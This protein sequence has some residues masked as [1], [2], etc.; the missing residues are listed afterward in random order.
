MITPIPTYK[1]LLPNAIKDNTKPKYNIM[2]IIA[3]VLFFIFMF[4]FF[5]KKS[6]IIGAICAVAFASYLTINMKIML[7]NEQNNVDDNLARYIDWSITTPL[8]LVTL[9]M[10][11]NITNPSVYV[12]F[13]ALDV[14]MIYLGYLAATS[15]DTTSLYTLY[16]FS[17]FFYLLIFALLLVFRP[18]LVLFFFLFLAW[19]VY[20]ILWILHETNKGNMTNQNYDYS[21]S[22][23]DI[24]SKIGYGLIL[25]L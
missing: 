12:F 13:I 10:K 8:L 17:C 22:A 16:G 23:L 3:C 19:S 25:P 20:P 24:F 2:Q 7:V 21:I 11:C 1:F 14:V 18:P 9:L 6:Y 5:A 4:Y 15:K